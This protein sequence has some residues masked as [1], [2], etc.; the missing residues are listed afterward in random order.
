MVEFA[1]ANFELEL[2]CDVA[3]LQHLSDVVDVK[4][5]LVSKDQRVLHQLDEASLVVALHKVVVAICGVDLVVVRML[6]H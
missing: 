2:I 4:I 6:K 1:I 3:M 5:S